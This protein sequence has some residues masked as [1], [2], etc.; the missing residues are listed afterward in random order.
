ME[1]RSVK[2]FSCRNNLRCPLKIN[3]FLKEH[4]EKCQDYSL[5]GLGSLVQKYET[6]PEVLLTKAE[7]LLKN[8]YEVVEVH[9][10]IGEIIDIQL[11]ELLTALGLKD[12]KSYEEK[13]SLVN[14]LG[15]LAPRILFKIRDFQT[16][17][18]NQSCNETIEKTE[19]HLDIATL[20]V[21]IIKRFMNNFFQDFQMSYDEPE[22]NWNKVK[23]ESWLGS[24]KHGIK[25][26]FNEKGRP[27]IQVIGVIDYSEIMNYRINS[28]KIEYIPLLRAFVKHSLWEVSPE[29]VYDDLCKEILEGPHNKCV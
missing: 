10:V 5:S 12:A 15:M 22:P 14:K 17:S 29:D 9:K 26:L 21:K 27:H 11:T 13:I 8:K 19:N 18:I 1:E 16:S 20:F 4:K 24:A 2:S 3:Q 6:E 25:F 28:S 23:D 7:L